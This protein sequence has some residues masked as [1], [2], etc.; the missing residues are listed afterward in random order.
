MC[1]YSK[2]LLLGP[3]ALV[4]I[5]YN[6]ALYHGQWKH[7]V[8][9]GHT[10]WSNWSDYLVVEHTLNGFISI[11]IDVDIDINIEIDLYTDTD[12]YTDINMYTDIDVYSDNDVYSD[13]DVYTDWHRCEH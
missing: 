2:L 3:P 1:C 11:N 4:F 5:S 9:L 7:S 8:F 13:T 12:M 10:L 6:I